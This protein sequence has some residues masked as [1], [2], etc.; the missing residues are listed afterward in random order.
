MFSFDVKTLLEYL[1]YSNLDNPFLTDLVSHLERMVYLLVV[2]AL[3][4]LG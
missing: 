4:M 3:G 1:L 2:N